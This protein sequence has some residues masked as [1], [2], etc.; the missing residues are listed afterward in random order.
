[1]S[2][3]FEKKNFCHTNLMAVCTA[4]DSKEREGCE[5]YGKSSTRNNCM[6]LKF[7]DEYWD[8]L[9]AQIKSRQIDG[10]R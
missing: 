5:F 7:D 4:K 1:M 3:L 8:C 10:V 9:K 6:H 2:I